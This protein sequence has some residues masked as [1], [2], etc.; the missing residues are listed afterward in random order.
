MSEQTLKE[1]TAKGLFWGSISSVVQQSL[2]LLF[3]LVLARILNAS[4]YGMV[5][6]LAIFSA[7]ASTIQESGFTAALT[8]QKEKR[9]EDYNAVFWFSTLVGLFFYVV[10]FFCAPYIAHFYRKPELISLS[11]IMF[12]GFVFGGLGIAS[13]AYLFK[14][15]MV[16]ERAKIDMVALFCSG[17]VGIILA[18]NGFAYYGLAIQ[19]TTYIGVGSLLKLYLAP[20]HPTGKLN[21]SPLKKMFVFSSK[22]I[23]TNVF[24]QINNNMY[25]VVLGRYCDV[26]LLGF[27]TQ[28]QKWT[29]MG[30]QLVSGMMSNVAQPVLVETVDDQ[31]RQLNVFEKM[32]HFGAF[33][34]FP[35]MLGIAFVSKE[36]V[37]IFL[38]DK[39][40]ES[41]IF[42]RLF[43]VWASLV[44]L[45]QLYGNLL[46]SHRQSGSYFIGVVGTGL[47]QLFSVFLL[48]VFDVYVMIWGYILS[49]SIGVLFL[50]FLSKKI[51][52]LPIIDI[53]KGIFPYLYC[54]FFSFLLT[55]LFSSCFHNVYLVFILKIFL[56]SILYLLFLKLV[57]NDLLNEILVHFGINI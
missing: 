44:Y 42:I 17:V 46:I 39:W 12:L 56:G 15:L 41:V 22:L 2:N 36:F 43:C 11:R 40:L 29:T 55:W 50:N 10:L 20:W 21:F 35:I 6:M 30:H 5:G 19:T 47:L 26:R 57:K 7:I 13:N 45:W 23:L 28:G 54:C 3:G 16:K 51:M 38:G 14:S 34:S 48:F 31:N 37:L 53:L 32:I 9:D 24:T 33:V 52:P 27:F 4:D 18:L 25:S 1:K 49:Y 8:N